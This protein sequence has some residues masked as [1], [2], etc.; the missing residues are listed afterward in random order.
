MTKIVSFIIQ[1]GG[2]GKTTT[3]VNI[4]SYLSRHELKVLCVDMDP[5]GN[6][7]QHFGYDSETLE[8]TLLQLFKNPDNFE[9]IVLKRDP[10]LHVLPNNLKT[11]SAEEELQ[12]SA[13]R[14]YL[15]RDLLAPVYSQYD[16]ILIDCPPTLG[17]FSINALAASSEFVLV[18]SP[19]FLPMKAIKPLYETFRMV[20]HRLNHALQFN[21]IMM[22]MCDFRTRHSQEILE[23]LKQNFPHKLYHAFIRN[24]VSLKEAAAYGMTIFEYNP[25]SLGAFDYQNLAA[26]FIRDHD[27]NL[28]KQEYYQSRFNTL[29]PQVREQILKVAKNNLSGY[30]RSNLEKIPGSNV[31][32]ESLRIERNK[33]I[34]ELFPYRIN[35]EIEPK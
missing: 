23:I 29:Q 10:R 15:L 8:T 4:A 16:Y 21:G 35:A 2:C 20:K 17:Q 24:N 11:A 28:A 25:R 1:K 3:T 32:K 33:I 19:E 22:T 26:E 27:K 7:T 5:Q 12:K 6:L 34:E 14:D 31:L 9:E 30:V 13:N 18:V